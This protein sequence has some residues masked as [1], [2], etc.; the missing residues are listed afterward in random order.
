MIRMD[1]AWS[2]QRIGLRLPP[3]GGIFLTGRDLSGYGLGFGPVVP[4]TMEEE[5]HQAH[6]QAHDNDVHE[7]PFM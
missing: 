1:S 7:T 5:E 2:R 3:R 6:H 4:S